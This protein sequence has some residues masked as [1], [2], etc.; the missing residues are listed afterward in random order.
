MGSVQNLKSSVFKSR[1]IRVIA[2]TCLM[3]PKIGEEENG[4]G[5]DRN[6]FTPFFPPLMR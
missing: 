5:K 3:Q 2:H 6:E 4:R 1:R